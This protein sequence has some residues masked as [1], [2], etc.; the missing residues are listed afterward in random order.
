MALKSYS[1]WKLGGKIGLWK[2]GGSPKPPTNSAK[3]ILW[4]SSEPFMRSLSRGNL[5][6]DKDGLLTD[7]SPNTNS[8]D[9]G[10]D[11]SEGVREYY[12][13]NLLLLCLLVESKYSICLSFLVVLVFAGFYSL[14]EFISS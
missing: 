4:K 6:G 10:R 12:P 14:L 8:G 13:C 11:L 3:P 5:F 1:E 7:N 2:Y 9:A